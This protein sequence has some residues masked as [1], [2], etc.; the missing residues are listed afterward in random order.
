MNPECLDAV[1]KYKLAE[2]GVKHGTI[3]KSIDEFN[4]WVEKLDV[5]DVLNILTLTKGA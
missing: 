3:N 1:A 4:S 2:Y 5:I